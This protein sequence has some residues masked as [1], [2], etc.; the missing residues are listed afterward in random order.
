MDEEI[1]NWR[2]RVAETRHELGGDKSEVLA[3]LRQYLEYRKNVEAEMQEKRRHGLATE[4]DG[5]EARYCTLE[6]ETW[7]AQA[8][9][10]WGQ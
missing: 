8:L 1:S 4:S 5:Q 10:L 3:D 2:R 7:L 9:Q 6:A